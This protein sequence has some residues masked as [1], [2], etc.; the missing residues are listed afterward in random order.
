MVFGAIGVYIVWRLGYR[1]PVTIA[2]GQAPTSI[3]SRPA[4]SA[5]CGTFTTDECQ[6][7][8][9]FQAATNVIDLH[10]LKDEQD[11]E[12]FDR[13]SRQAFQARATLYGLPPVPPLFQEVDVLAKRA[14]SNW[15]T[16]NQTAKR[17]VETRSRP[18]IREALDGFD[19]VV[20][21]FDEVDRKLRVIRATH[22]VST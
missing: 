2:N 14:L 20:D 7:N 19:Q 22:S 12:Y 15:D 11:L 17:A 21:E 3:Q 18:L 10:L 8:R 1:E 13:M 16:V 5:G 4:G 6:W 9:G